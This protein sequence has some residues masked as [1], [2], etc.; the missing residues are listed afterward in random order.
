[1]GTDLTPDC[2]V[3]VLE[4]IVA[5]CQWDPLYDLTGWH[6]VWIHRASHRVAVAAEEFCET[7]A[8]IGPAQERV[9]R[10]IEDTACRAG[11]GVADHDLR[12][13]MLLADDIGVG[14]LDD[15]PRFGHAH[16]RNHF[17]RISR[18]SGAGHQCLADR[19][20][21]RVVAKEKSR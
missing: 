6:V 4:I 21:R 16:D 10:P 17:K 8:G 13:V 15:Q 5:A 19:G 20:K 1:M 9:S 18:R 12:S 2:I 7:I 3:L 11:T 14:L